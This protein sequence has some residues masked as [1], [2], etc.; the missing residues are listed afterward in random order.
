MSIQSL[1]SV[2]VP[3]SSMTRYSLCSRDDRTRRVHLTAPEQ[4]ILTAAENLS[5]MCNEITEKLELR[6]FWLSTLLYETLDFD[7]PGI[8]AP[9]DACLCYRRNYSYME[10]CLV[11]PN[12]S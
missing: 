6:L 4:D 12:M 1:V 11:N 2:N 5:T 3:F 10:D 9:L 8:R 7:C